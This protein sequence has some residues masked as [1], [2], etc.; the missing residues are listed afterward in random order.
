[1]E[2]YLYEIK[3]KWFLT[4]PLIVYP[5]FQGLFNIS[6]KQAYLFQYTNIHFTYRDFS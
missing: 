2:Y 4:L 6:G 3:K 1:M 5:N